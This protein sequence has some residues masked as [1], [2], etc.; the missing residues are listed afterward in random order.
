MEEINKEVSSVRERLP[1]QKDKEN[2]EMSLKDSY[3][4]YLRI[5]PE[6]AELSND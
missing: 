2:L 5:H 4:S 6:E 3:E 1:H